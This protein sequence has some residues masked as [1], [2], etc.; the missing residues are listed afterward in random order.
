MT[1]SAEA[2]EIFFTFVGK[3]DRMSLYGRY[4]DEELIEFLRSGDHA[5]FTEIFNRYWEPM[6]NAAFRLLQSGEDAEEVIQEI[7]VA[8]YIRRKE[9]R[10]KSSLEAYLRS[11]LKYKAI[12]AYRSQQAHYARLD[13]LIEETRLSSPAPDDELAFRELKEKIH[14]AADKLP[15]K[16]REVFLMSRFEQLSHRDIANRLGISVS[17]VKKHLNK[18]MKLLRA[19]L[20]DNR[21]DLLLLAFFTFLH[22]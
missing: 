16:C 14:R 18:A 12:D 5:A 13:D 8:L 20:R 11:A 6:I 21:L 22:R 10:L 2:L 19:E 3:T 15:E 17:T 7:F 9:I 4:K 1:R